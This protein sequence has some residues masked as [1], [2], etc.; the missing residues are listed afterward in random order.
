MKHL[1]FTIISILFIFT[2]STRTTFAQQDA[3]YS[4]YMFNG[5]YVNPAYAGSTGNAGFAAFY[6]KQWVNIE[7]APQT[8]SVSGQGPFGKRQQYG[9]GGFLEY[10]EIGVHQRITGYGA[11]AYRFK[12]PIGAVALGIQGGV[13]YL[14]S[15][16]TDITPEEVIT[17]PDPVF[18][19]NSSV[20]LPNFGLGIWFNTP[21]FFAGLSAPHL[22]NNKLNDGQPNI[23]TVGR[24]YRHYLLNTGVVLKAGK[25]VKVVPSILVKAIPQNAPVQFD[26]NLSV[27]LVDMLWIGTSF[28]FENK[29]T[30]E[31]INAI[32]GFQFGNGL[33]LGYAYDYTLSSLNNFT[34]GSHEVTLGYDLRKKVDRLITPRYF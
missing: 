32:L 6:R 11:Y 17:N 5:M 1:I 18:Q 20:I 9:L 23:T 7:G 14:R 19:E 12:L 2:F 30:P 26:T 15:N 22:I 16:F 29:F 34:S 31:S 27:F 8:I 28:R 13:Q 33:R 21:A 24:Q 25:S 3:R 10:D 4:M